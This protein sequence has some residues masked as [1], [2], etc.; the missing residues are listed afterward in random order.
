MFIRILLLF[1]LPFCA[2]AQSGSVVT[3]T[4]KSEKLR[5]NAGENPNRQCS[6]YLPP[7][8]DSGNER[9]PVIYYLHGFM[10]TDQIS[11]QMKTRLDAAIQKQKI[12]PYILVIADNNT[13][14]QGSFYSA[15]S[16]IGD[17]DAFMA[18]ELVQYM[19]GHFRTIPKKE[20]RGIGGHSMGGYGAIKIGM[21]HPDVFSVVYGMSPGLMAAVKEFGPN[22]TSFKE[23][24][25]IKTV[26]DLRKSYYPKVLVAVGRA[27]SPNP[28]KPPFYCDMPFTYEGDSL[29]V[30]PDI[31]EKWHN[32]MPV[33]MLDTYAGNVRQLKALK[34]DWGRND[35]PRFPQQ[36]MMFSVKLENLGIH[37]YAEEY[38][39]T[40]V[41][42]IWTEDGRVL[43]AMLPFF[44]NYLQFE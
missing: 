19:D 24:Q 40:H 44:N 18:E 23:L 33:E 38:I 37:H 32:N 1:F 11:P 21:L 25:N 15:S 20:S 28:N 43:N 41:D 36:N 7:G 26:E 34:L 8:Y 42:K 14:F 4:L 9:Y 12:R 16:Y 30:H 10:G 27:W 6:V 31:L 29:I 35:A 39:G 13:L 3:F 17:W 22:S 5:N 2:V